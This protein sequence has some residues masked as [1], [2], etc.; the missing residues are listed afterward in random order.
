VKDRAITAGILAVLAG[1][2]FAGA[3][4]GSLLSSDGAIYA[5]SAREM[6]RS[7]DLLTPTWQGEVL[8]EKGPVHTALIAGGMALFGETEFGARFSTLVFAVVFA[9]VVFGFARAMGM[10]RIAAWIAV[11]CAVFPG[12]FFFTTRRPLAEIPAVTMGHAGVYL[13]VFRRSWAGAGLLW[14]LVLLIKYPIGL[15][16]AGGGLAGVWWLGGR[17]KAWGLG[18]AVAVAV[19]APW[20]VYMSIRYGAAFWD[21]YLFYHLF[22]RVGHAIATTSDPLFY[23]RVLFPRDGAFLLLWVLGLVW[24]GYRALVRDR[25]ALFLLVFS[26]VTLLPAQVSATR[27]VHYLVWALPGLGLAVGYAVDRLS[28]RAS[29]TAGLAVVLFLSGVT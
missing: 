18:L 7:G 14:G 5:Q 2:F 20:H 11:F 23:L 27:H 16:Y 21:V 6:L 26:L 8:F 12:V 17:V 10:G 13:L 3:G 4:Q 9:L 28:P 29:L 24:V 25:N 22:G 15:L 19:A 1:L